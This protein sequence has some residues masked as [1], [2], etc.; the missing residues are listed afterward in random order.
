[1]GRFYPA[2]A[3]GPSVS[4]Y[5]LLKH[6]SSQ[7]NI[8]IRVVTTKIGMKSDTSEVTEFS[9]TRT[10]DRSLR[11]PYRV[12]LRSL[13]VLRKS[14]VIHLNSLFDLV[15]FVLVHFAL[16]MGKHVIWSV[17]GELYPEALNHKRSKTIL[18][19]YYKLIVRNVTFHVT[20]N[21]ELEHLND[22]FPEN[23]VKILENFADMY[24]LK[25]RHRE[26]IISFV[27]RIVRHK[28][29]HLL[30]E[31]F[32]LEKMSESGFK[33][34]LAG[35]IDLNYKSYLDKMNYHEFVEYAG[36][37][38]LNDKSNLLA[39][40]SCLVLPSRSENF[41]NVVLEA[42]NQ[43]TISF[44]TCNSPWV[45]IAQNIEGVICQQPTVENLRLFL[46]RVKTLQREDFKKYSK[47]LRFFTDNFTASYKHRVKGFY[48]I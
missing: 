41:G 3:G 5:Y 42:C 18:L 44:V 22:W 26:R 34:V 12:I 31:A 28:N 20:S 43:G 35:S 37:L 9:V 19:K 33:L 16:L 27:G 2:S 40:S 4:M 15:S 7:E 17:R 36:Y 8:S 24:R 25:P 48:D 32:L 30:C 6:L 1:M 38:D 23:E 11:F 10:V 45:E 39:V 14:D 47:E 46:R 13:L 21:Q 29:V